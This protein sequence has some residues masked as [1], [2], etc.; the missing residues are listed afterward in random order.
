MSKTIM[1]E[2]GNTGLASSRRAIEKKVENL[3]EALSELNN[4]VAEGELVEDCFTFR[5]RLCDK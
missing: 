2:P 3:L 4:F 5:M 1:L